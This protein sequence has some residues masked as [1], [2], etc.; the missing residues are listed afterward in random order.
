MLTIAGSDSCGGAGIQGDIKTFEAF[1]VYSLTVLT[2]VT[3]QNTTGV[4]AVFDLPASIVRKQLRS[5]MSDIRVDAVKIGML[6]NET[7]IKTVASELRKGRV[8][9]IVLDPVMRAKS[10]DPLLAASAKD[11]LLEHL[12]PLASLVTP[13][14][15]E[16][17][18][19]V[20]IKIESER[21][22]KRAAEALI[23]RGA[24]AALVKGGHLASAEAVD[25][26]F[27]G[28][29]FHEFRAERIDV[30][31]GIHGTGCALA[32]AIAAG[33]ARGQTLY[34]SVENAKTYLTEAIKRRYY[35]GR[36]CPVLSHHWA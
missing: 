21:D 22:M 25:I 20:S 29:A 12:I 18:E 14:I 26:L 34:Q 15:P 6:S 31:E 11:S 9:N 17:E 24:A 4:E 7:I 13:N 1:H 28:D 19:L 32:S 30:A 16:A 33:L 8:G 27:D 3:A 10:G 23:R 35:I 5:V 2:S 36:G